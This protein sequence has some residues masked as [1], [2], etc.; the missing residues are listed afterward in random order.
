MN[1]KKTNKWKDILYSWTGETLFKYPYSPQQST[2]SMQSLSKF[3]RAYFKKLEQIIL[4]CIWNP[5]K[6]PNGQ[7]NPKKEEKSWRYHAPW[8]QTVL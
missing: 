3:P 6:F 1:V 8:F 5:K 4:K 2:D 7:N